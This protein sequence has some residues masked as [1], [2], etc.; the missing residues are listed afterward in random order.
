MV[1]VFDPAKI[2]RAVPGWVNN[3]GRSNDAPHQGTNQANNVPP[4]NKDEAAELMTTTISTDGKASKFLLLIP[5]NF[6]PPQRHFCPFS[7]PILIG[8]EFVPV[9][10]ILIPHYRPFNAM[11]PPLA[12]YHHQINKW[13]LEHPLHS[14]HPLHHLLHFRLHQP[15]FPLNNWFDF[16]KFA[17]AFVP[18][19]SSDASAIFC[20]V[21]V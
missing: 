7:L 2:Q 18:F 13:I 5:S 10:A 12:Q 1:R 3:S 4:I 21:V 9:F 14:P 8:I 19:S 20:S 16:T 6:Q 17:L 15:A 11:P